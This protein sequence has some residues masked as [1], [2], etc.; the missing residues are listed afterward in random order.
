MNSPKA[1]SRCCGLSCGIWLVLLLVVAI[2]AWFRFTRDEPVT[3]ASIE[4]HFKYGSTGG[5]R[6]SG[7]PLSIWKVLPKIFQQYLPGPYD[8]QKPYAVFG[9]IYEDGKELPVGNPSATCKA[10]PRL[11]QLRHLPCRHGAR[12]T[13][14][15]AAAPDPGNAGECG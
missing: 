7:I 13:G 11:S 9:F 3:Y 15:Q 5:E 14:E 8:A 1:C 2:Y 12:F 10:G 6:A 4:D